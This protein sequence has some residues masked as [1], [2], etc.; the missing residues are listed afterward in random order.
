MEVKTRYHDMYTQQVLKQSREDK[1][2]KTF[3]KKKN[4]STKNYKIH[5]LP[6]KLYNFENN[7]EFKYNYPKLNSFFI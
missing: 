2:H 5:G 6:L 7:G 4:I 3:K 1:K